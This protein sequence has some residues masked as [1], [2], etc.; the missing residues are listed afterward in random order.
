MAALLGEVLLEALAR[1]PPKMEISGKNGT[2]FVPHS[3]RHYPEADWIA[4]SGWIRT[5]Q[6]S[7]LAPVGTLL[8]F[9]ATER[10]EFALAVH[11]LMS[12]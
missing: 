6:W 11:K 5:V 7:N 3:A 12:P 9:A 8:G 10:V 2:R 1:L 4:V